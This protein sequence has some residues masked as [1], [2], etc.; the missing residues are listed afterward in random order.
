MVPLKEYL[1]SNGYETLFLE[2]DVTVP[3]GQMSIRVE[4]FLEMLGV[5]ELF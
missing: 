2:F 1:K 4:A 3:V 5:E